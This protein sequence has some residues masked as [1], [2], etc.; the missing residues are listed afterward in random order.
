MPRFQPP[1]HGITFDGAKW[2]VAEVPCQFPTVLRRLGGGASI[3]R[4]WAEE[5]Y[6]EYAAQQGTDQSFDRLHE[7]GGFG[8][9]EIVALLVDRCARLEAQLEECFTP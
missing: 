4:T 6:K 1:S 2:N 3:P 5:A 9:T 8:L 7:R